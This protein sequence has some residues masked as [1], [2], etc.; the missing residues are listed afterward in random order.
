MPEALTRAPPPSRGA[1]SRLIGND[2]EP[3]P[4]RQGALEPSMIGPNITASP[5]ARDRLGVR[6]HRVREAGG[7]E[8]PPDHT[9]CD[10]QARR[11]AFP[12]L[13]SATGS[14]QRAWR[15]GVTGR[16]SV[17][18]HVMWRS[19]SEP[20]P[21]LHRAPAHVGSSGSNMGRRATAHVSGDRVSGLA[22]RETDILRRPAPSRIAGCH[23]RIRRDETISSGSQRCKWARPGR[24]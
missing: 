17:T 7:D 18:A 15:R 8:A 23:I 21:V 11:I 4:V 16:P 3:A 19:L 22:S 10:C 6:R 13:E 5:R 14:W 24:V 12:E 9:P 1:S 20:S 2:A